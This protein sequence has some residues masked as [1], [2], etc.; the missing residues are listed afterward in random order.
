MIVVCVC[1]PTIALSPPPS[2]L[3]LSLSPEAPL[4]IQKVPQDVTRLTGV[5]C[6]AAKNCQFAAIHCNSS[7]N[8]CIVLQRGTVFC[9]LNP[10]APF[11][12]RLK[13]IASQN[14]GQPF[15]PSLPEITTFLGFFL[16][17]LYLSCMCNT[18]C[19]GVDTDLWQDH[20][21]FG[22]RCKTP[23][24]DPNPNPTSNPAQNTLTN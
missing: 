14:G 18:P 17:N 9:R 7:L 24:N 4:K 3:L 5:F 8:H 23:R 19:R 11:Y 16:R 15:C 2:L 22:I 21:R 12:C 13:T 20:S 10:C 1:A 6:S